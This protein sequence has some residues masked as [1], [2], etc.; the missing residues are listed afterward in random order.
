MKTQQKKKLCNGCEYLSL[1]P[2][3]GWGCDKYETE[4]EMLRGKPVRLPFCQHKKEEL[5]QAIN[6]TKQG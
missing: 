5:A 3:Y 2:D 6:S 4:V 1:D